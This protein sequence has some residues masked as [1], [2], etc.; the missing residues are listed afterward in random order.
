MYAKEA[1]AHVAAAGVDWRQASRTDEADRQAELNTNA[2]MLAVIT[3]VTRSRY[4][5]T[6]CWASG[7]QLCFLGQ[8]G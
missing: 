5:D 8:L 4:G 7:E 6:F 1:L 2:R 3:G